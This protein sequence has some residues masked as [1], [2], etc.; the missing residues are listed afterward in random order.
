MPPSIHIL[1]R[2][3]PL[4]LLISGAL[5]A[6]FQPNPRFD[7]TSTGSE[8]STS[9]GEGPGEVTEP[10]DGGQPG[11]S[12]TGEGTT[13]ELTGSTGSSSSS[14]AEELSSSSGSSSGGLEFPLCPYEPPG[15]QVTLA[16]VLGGVAEDFTLRPCGDSEV[17]GPLWNPGFEADHYA[18]QQCGDAKCG[19]CDADD[20]VQVGLVAPDPF[21]GYAASLVPGTCA[22]LHV[23]WDLMVPGKDDL[24]APSMVA[25]VELREGA[26]AVVPSMLYHRTQ[27]LPVMDVIGGF[28]LGGG[29]G[30]AGAIEC[31]CDGDDCC[32][33]P[34]GSRL[35]A[36]TAAAAGEAIEIPTLE[37]Q[38]A[39]QGLGLGMIEGSPN[40]AELALVR[41]FVPSE[42][43]A[44]PEY[45]WLFALDSL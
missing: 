24:C 32:R 8:S 35:V 45:E 25:L 19:A 20:V 13:L 40:S 42:C 28:E 10:T 44:L 17:M 9:T 22:Q 34:P 31:A 23:R 39:V 11:S 1:H 26:P 15:V 33:E 18:L 37:S 38:Q 5:S 2:V 41:A 30:G 16:T 36:F 27:A 29:P 6:C 7:L 3:R 4:C 12:S 14:G 21:G 43:G